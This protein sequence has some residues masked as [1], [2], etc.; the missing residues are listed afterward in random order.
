MAGP[1]VLL[2]I[3]RQSGRG[4]SS[5]GALARRAALDRA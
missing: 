2:R 3:L 5:F 4:H 1:R